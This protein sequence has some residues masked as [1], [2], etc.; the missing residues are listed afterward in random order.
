M[1]GTT[2]SLRGLDN[3]LYYRHADGR[4]VNDTGC[5]NT[6]A[7]DEPPVLQLAMDALRSWVTRTG[8]DG[9][10]FDLATVMGR[11]RHGLQPPARRCSRRSSR[12]RCCRRLIMIAE[13]WD[14]GPGG[15]Q[16]GPV[17]GALAG[18]ERPLPRRGAALLAR[19]GA[20]RGRLRHAHRGLLRHLRRRAPPALGQHQ[21]RR[22]A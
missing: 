20:C 21:L 10:R 14:V 11:T 7:L 13:P 9:F 8:I 18:M 22:R 3:A 17:P 12:T 16:L 2:L 6:L 15:Y 5:G 4:L 19:R 1:H